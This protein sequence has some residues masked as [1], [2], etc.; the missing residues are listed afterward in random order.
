MPWMQGYNHK[1]EYI[2]TQGPLPN[3]TIDF[4]RM[5]GEQNVHII[6]MVTNPVENGMVKCHKYW[7]ERGVGQFGNMVITTVSEKL[8]PEFIVRQFTLA[9]NSKDRKKKKSS[10]IQVIQ[11]SYM[12]AGWIWTGSSNS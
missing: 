1:N 12:T 3:T 8:F 6:V 5:I 11:F 4:W 9:M 2:A 10:V 7:P